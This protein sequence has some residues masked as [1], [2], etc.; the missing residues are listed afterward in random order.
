MS[1]ARTGLPTSLTPKV[2][3]DVLRYEPRH[4]KAIKAR[5]AKKRR[6]LCEDM[7][8]SRDDFYDK[9]HE[10]LKDPENRQTF[11]LAAKSSGTR[12][13]TG[14]LFRRISKHYIDP[15]RH[16]ESFRECIHP[17]TTSR[18]LIDAVSEHDDDD[19]HLANLVWAVLEDGGLSE[20]ELAEISAEYP[21]VGERLQ[22][23]VDTNTMEEQRAP[24]PMG[25]WPV[26]TP[27]SPGQR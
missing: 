12:N 7:S 1:T 26:A 13:R 22:T 16:E 10:L 25:R 6:T 15:L 20:D 4:W 2:L 8:V 11:E 19:D 5:I 23:V 9:L 27:G 21:G 3:R 18:E 17:E 24:E 14:S